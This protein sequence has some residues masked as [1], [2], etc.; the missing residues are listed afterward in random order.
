MEDI[1]VGD[2]K[3][4]DIRVG[5]SSKVEHTREVYSSMLGNRVGQKRLE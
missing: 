3:V 1:R 5:D 2:N 4:E